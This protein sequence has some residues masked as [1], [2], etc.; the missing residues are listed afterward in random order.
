[1]K[2]RGSSLGTIDIDCARMK[3]GDVF[4]HRQTETGAAGVR[5]RGEKWLKNSL[6]ERRRNA[7]PGIAN[8]DPD[9][10]TFRACFDIERTAS[11]HGVAG[12]QGQIDE[13]LLNLGGIGE[14]HGEFGVDR[15]R[16]PDGSRQHTAQQSDGLPE[17]GL[18]GDQFETRGIAGNSD[19]VAYHFRAAGCGDLDVVEL[20]AQGQAGTEPD[21]RE[22]EVVQDERELVVEVMRDT[23]G[24]RSDELQALRVS[25]LIFLIGHVRCAELCTFLNFP[26]CTSWDVGMPWCVPLSIRD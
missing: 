2:G 13:N 23:G 7:V 3:S 9:R 20:R 5:F 21:Q 1:M 25:G 14:D 4:D 26:D 16:D 19:E 15:E 24:H 11:G 22:V 8:G 18:Q 12:V 10:T 17:D 6:E